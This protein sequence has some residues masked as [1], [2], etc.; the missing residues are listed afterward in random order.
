LRHAQNP[1][2]RVYSWERQIKISLI[3]EG[4]TV[5]HM[6][7]D[8]MVQYADGRKELVEVKSPA[9][10]T[11]LYKFKLKFLQATLLNDNPDIKYSIV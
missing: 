8:F 11:P 6:V 1:R 9:T 4:V 3:A 2:D 10:M 5:G 7:V